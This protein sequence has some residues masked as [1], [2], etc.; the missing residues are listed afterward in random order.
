VRYSAYS[1][2]EACGK[3]VPYKDDSYACFRTKGHGGE[4]VAEA[5]KAGEA[6][7]VRWCCRVRLGQPHESWCPLLTPVDGGADD[8]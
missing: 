4:C 5:G 7:G 8:K 6:D 2:E 1:N 3:G